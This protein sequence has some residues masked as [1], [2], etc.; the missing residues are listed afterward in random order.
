MKYLGVDRRKFCTFIA[1]DVFKG[2]SDIK[3]LG[4]IVKI[5]NKKVFNAIVKKDLINQI[6][7]LH[8][9]EEVI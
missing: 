3:I 2:S 4:K 8:D 7:K 1:K 5:G 6:L 9:L